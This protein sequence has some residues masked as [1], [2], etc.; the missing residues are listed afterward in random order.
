[1]IQLIEKLQIL[2]SETAL[3]VIHSIASCFS[4]SSTPEL[5]HFVFFSCYTDYEMSFPIHNAPENRVGWGDEKSCLYGARQTGDIFFFLES[6]R[7]F[8]CS[9]V[10]QRSKKIL[11]KLNRKILVRDFDQNKLKTL[12]G[13][14]RNKIKRNYQSLRSEIW[15]FFMFW[16][17]RFSFHWNALSP[18]IAI[19]SLLFFLSKHLF[20]N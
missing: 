12:R 16:K 1:M 6:P 18:L 7:S 10:T 2:S 11:C 5:F 17:I 20:I 4:A 3:S 9:W 19:L 15:T 14:K 13:V 8:L